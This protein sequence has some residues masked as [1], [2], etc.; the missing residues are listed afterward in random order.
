MKEFRRK[1][2]N[3]H[4]RFS[5][6]RVMGDSGMVTYRLFLRDLRGTLHAEVKRFAQNTSRDEIAVKVNTMR[7]ELRESVDSI[8]FQLLGVV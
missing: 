2:P 7:H 6:G 1:C 3:P 8:E 5:W 4:A